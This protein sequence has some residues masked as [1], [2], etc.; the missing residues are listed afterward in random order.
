MPINGVQGSGQ[1]PSQT[2]KAT[3]S[4]PKGNSVCSGCGQCGAGIKAGTP[5]K[6]ADS[7]STNNNSH[8]HAHGS[9]FEASSSD[10]TQPKIQSGACPQGKSGCNNCGGCG[11]S[12]AGGRFDSNG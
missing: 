12:K 1:G 8:H 4:C 10:Q 5:V 6:P 2:S 11:K 9:A 3:V 7:S